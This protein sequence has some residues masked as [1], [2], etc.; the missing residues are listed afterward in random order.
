VVQ[1]GNTPK[2]QLANAFG[3]G[4]LPTLDTTRATAAPPAAQ[5]CLQDLKAGAGLSPLTATDR[6]DAFS[7]C[8]TFALYE[9]ALKLTLG[10]SDAASVVAAISRIGT[11]FAAAATH[12]GVTDFASGRRTGPAQGRLFAWS[13]GC[14]CFDY[15]G[16]AFN[17]VSR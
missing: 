14:G 15:T 12:G 3:L 10:T 17:L 2:T 4:W 7:I 13:T 8:D 5:R 9:S 11:G 16:A 1:E 6:Y